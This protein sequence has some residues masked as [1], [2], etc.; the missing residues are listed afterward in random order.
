MELIMEPVENKVESPNNPVKKGTILIMEDQRGFR[1]VYRDVLEKDGYDV[2]EGTDGEE[3]WDIIINKKPDLVLLDL[4][5]PLL[6]G[7]QV[8][9]KIR[10]SE[11][12]KHIPVIIF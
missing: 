4:G 8:L 5:L 3:G 6:D 7:F 2:L 10:R 9:E 12:T 1:R 11:Q